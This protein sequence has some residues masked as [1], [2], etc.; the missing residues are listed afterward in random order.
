MFLLANAHDWTRVSESVA[1]LQADNFYKS[2]GQ[3]RQ[4]IRTVET[5]ADAGDVATGLLAMAKTHHGKWSK[6]ESDELSPLITS[7]VGSYDLKLQQE[8]QADQTRW[9]T[10]AV[11][12]GQCHSTTADKVGPGG[13]VYAETE[14]LKKRKAKLKACHAV[15]KAWNDYKDPDQRECK[16]PTTARFGELSDQDSALMAAL[17][18][19]VSTYQSTLPVNTG[20]PANDCSSDQGLFEEQQCLVRRL[21]LWNC[22]AQVECTMTVALADLKQS[23]EESQAK[24]RASQL[25]FKKLIC[26]VRAIVGFSANGMW[27]LGGTTA[28]L[29]ACDSTELDPDE[30]MLNL[31]MPQA[32]HC[33]GEQDSAVSVYPSQT[34]DVMCSDWKTQEYSNWDITEYT[35]PTNCQVTCAAVPTTPAPTAAPS[36]APTAAAGAPTAET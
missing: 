27:N 20:L 30:L 21:H 13:E 10:Q 8:H 22:K 33:K 7:L 35:V 1:L 3:L 11:E 5:A 26:Q 2:L 34:I 12:Q 31:E 23:L 24:R 17:A 14:E 28:A 19:K 36:A 18:S 6:K 29:A 15:D 16:V 9:N 4:I 32:S 25:S